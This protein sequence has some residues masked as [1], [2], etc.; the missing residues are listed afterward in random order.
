MGRFT[1]SSTFAEKPG[2]IAISKKMLKTAC[3]DMFSLFGIKQKYRITYAQMSEYLLLGDSQPAIVHS[4]SPFL[5]AA[6]SDEMDAVVMVRF[7]EKLVKKYG[8]FAL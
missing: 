8:L 5:V 1:D 3:P 2:A 4:L 6:Y 7:D